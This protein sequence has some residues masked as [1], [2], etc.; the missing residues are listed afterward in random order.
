MT[1]AAPG[2][3][4]NRADSKSETRWQRQARR[5][6]ALAAATGVANVVGSAHHNI[7]SRASSKRNRNEKLKIAIE[8]NGMAWR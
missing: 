8:N 2:H 5:R 3:I 4:N 6:R 1:K 7:N